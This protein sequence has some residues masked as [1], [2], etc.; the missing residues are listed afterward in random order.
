[1][2]DTKSRLNLVVRLLVVRLKRPTPVRLRASLLCVWLLCA[3]AFSVYAIAQ[4]SSLAFAGLRTVAGQGQ[5]NAIRADAPG[6]LYLLLDQGDGIR[7]LKTDPSATTVLAQAHIGSAGDIGLALALDPTGNVYVTGTST[8]GTLTGTPGTAYPTA[9]GTSTNSFIAS[10]DSSLNPMWLTFAGTGKIASNSIIATATGVFITGSIFSTTLPVTSSAI[11]QSPAAGSFQNGFVEEFN[12]SG[13][14]LLY[15]TYLTGAS[16]DTAPSG[17][18]VDPAGNAY[19][20]GYTTAPGYPTVN[21]LVPNRIPATAGSTAGPTSG[22]LT[23]LTPAG[24]GLIFSTFIPGAGL[25][26]IALDPVAQNLLLSGNIAIGQFPV[27]TVQTGILPTPYQTLL[28]LPLD[29]S[30]VI[31]STLLAPGTQSIATPA[32]SGTAWVI[33]DLTTP[34]LPAASLSPIGDTFAAH[35]T[36]QNTVD[37]TARFGGLPTAKPAFASAPVSLTSLIVDATGQPTFAG[38][39][40][41]QASSSL[42]PT[43]TYDVPLYNSPNAV[44]PSTIRDTI[45]A[46]CNGSLCP[47]SAAYVTRLANAPAPSL[48]LSADAAPNLTLR[49]LGATAADSLTLTST[50]FTIAT[51]SP[52]SLPAGAE[53]SIALTGTGPGSLTLQAAN[54]TTQIIAIPAFTAPQA[55]VVFS[56]KELDFGIQTSTSGPATRTITVSNFTAQPQ[57]F[58]SRQETSA[59]TLP[60]TLAESA[61]DCTLTGPNTKLLAPGATCHITLSL[62]ASST[63]ANDTLL[64]AQWLIGASS[65]GR[66]VLV[67][68]YTQAAALSLSAAEVD[69]GTQYT[70]GLRLPRYLYL[71]NN[72]DATLAHTL[73]ASIPPFTIQDRCP[74]QLS[75]HTVCQLQIDYLPTQTPSND[76]TTLA[77]D[78]GLSALL[79]GQAL[80][81]PGVNGST[82]NPNLTVSPA[83]I[84]FPNAVVVTTISSSTQT[85]TIGN[86]G[87]TAFPL[88]LALSGDFTDTTNCLA[89]LAA[90][91]SCTVVLTF[92]PSQPGTRQ[93][94]LSIS[95]GASSTPSHVSLAGTGASILPANNGTLDLGSVIVG[96]P[97]VQWFKITQPFSTFTAATSADFTTILV[98]DIGYGHG[99]PPTSAFSSSSSGTCLN[100]WLGLQFKPS[101][102]G[103]R[104]AALNLTS[105]PSG[106]PYTLTLTGTGLPS[107]GLILAPA[108]Q[109]F[110]TV[111]LHSVSAP[112]LFTLTNLTS[113]PI[114]ITPPAITGDF[115]LSAAP[116]GGAPCSGVLAASATCFLQIVF[117]PTASGQRAGTLTITTTAGVVSTQLSGFGAPD[118]GLALNPTA[119]IFQNVPGQSSTTQAI[120]V[121]N[122]GTAPLQIA[123][124]TVTLS[125]FLPTTACATLAPAATCTI[126]VV[127][128]PAN[129][130]VTATLQIPVT[131]ATTATSYTVPLAG[132]YTTQ[133]IG[134]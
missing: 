112:T 12:P 63:S 17:L 69:F 10:F 9:T 118:P 20:T 113:S 16:G 84:N 107:V 124:P 59:H 91:S 55:A 116:T 35:I 3:V 33:S 68:G 123:T 70:G 22:F 31:A 117:A 106:G 89:T 27:A 122:T 28:R 53:C 51:N 93:G 95:T 72:S 61:S 5:F 40:T 54:A 2:S 103:L 11:L 114:T 58:I 14:A 133:D 45:P 110:G 77:L 18:A 120:N 100:C 66:D 104:S 99:Q 71:S 52:T 78:Q 62:A 60:Y 1:M 74:T 129:A 131:S 102:T 98:E 21:A 15:A 44:L 80:S 73:V 39:V 19:I 4:S 92:A 36:A 109:D 7:L 25:T 30:T 49:N 105:S 125:N 85:V 23:K 8:S 50:T 119:L 48:A 65:S 134:L 64:N 79:T 57:T 13:T 87:S 38:S 132:A 101:A 82:V 97:V 37:Q 46:T 81:P 76:T 75:P 43:E 32:P 24:D 56:P 130:A 90:N 128:S 83:Y 29:G 47:G 96:E 108:T 111:P 88:T 86:T 67:T 127:F 121:T 41:P 126:T 42:L 115:S 94:L 34:L 26:S 6:N